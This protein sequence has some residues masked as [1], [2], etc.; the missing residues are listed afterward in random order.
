MNDCIALN[1]S[2]L[3][4]LLKQDNALAFQE[5]YDRY[6]QK[7]YFLAHRRLKS[8][9]AAEEIVQN[10][11]LTIWRKRSTLNI[12]EP[13]AYLAAVTRYAVYHYVAA[14]KRRAT[15]EEIA[16]SRQTE[17]VGIEMLIEDKLLLEIVRQQAN[18]LPQ[19]CRL[20]FIYNKLEDQPLPE[21]AERLNIS[22]KTAEAHLTKALRQIRSRLK[23]HAFFIFF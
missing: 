11:F 16:G 5:L 23:D 9:T 22:V 20:V 3:L 2:E 7:L 6:W 21:V 17:S 15:K 1:D 14:E 18:E 10:V 19:K 8:A 4:R 13:A 12:E